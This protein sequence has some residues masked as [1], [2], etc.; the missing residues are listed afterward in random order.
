MTEY[1]NGV[2]AS[3]WSWIS[4]LTVQVAALGAF[5]W[6]VDLPMRRRGWPQVRYALWAV[7]FVK[8]MLPPTLALPTGMAGHLLAQVPSA[9]VVSPA[10][11]ERT[12]VADPD[13]R[14]PVAAYPAHLA[15]RDAMPSSA[16]LSRKAWAM[17]AWLAVVVSLGTWLV[18]RLAALSRLVG[19]GAP[20][21]WA[22]ECLAVAASRMGIKRV[23]RIVAVSGM[24]S[25]AVFGLFRPVVLIPQSWRAEYSRNELSHVLLHEAAHIRRL[26]LVANALQ[27][28]LHLLFWFHPFVWLAGR[29][30]RELRELCCDASVARVL[31]TET[32]EYR[33]TLMAAAGRVL[34]MQPPFSLGLLGLFEN[35]ARFRVRL[36]HLA[37]PLWQRRRLRL[38]TALVVVTAMMLFVVPMAPLKAMSGENV[39]AAAAS[40]SERVG[41]SQAVDASPKAEQAVKC[42]GRVVDSEGNGVAGAEVVIYQPGADASHDNVIIA[43]GVSGADGVFSFDATLASEFMAYATAWKEGYAH[44][45]YYW[46]P[47]G[48]GGMETVVRLGKP[49]VL[50][51]HVVDSSGKPISGAEVRVG[52]GIPYVDTRSGVG[53]R[54][55]GLSEYRKPAIDWLITTTGADGAFSFKDIPEDAKA[56]VT[57]SAP[58][59]ARVSTSRNPVQKQEDLYSYDAGQ[60][61]IVVTLPPES[62][63]VGKVLDRDTGEGVGGVQIW[64][65]PGATDSPV[66]AADGTFRVGALGAREYTLSVN[67]ATTPDRVAEPVKVTTAAGETTGGVTIVLFG[68]G[69]L[70]VTVTDESTG[71]PIPGASISV[72][73]ASA[74]E[75]E[76]SGGGAAGDNGVATARLLPG[77]YILSQV[78][79]PAR[80]HNAATPKE[81]VDIVYGGT[82]TLAVALSPTLSRLE[83][84]V[85]DADGAP[86]DGARFSLAGGTLEPGEPEPR[87]DASGRFSFRVRMW[88][89]DMAERP[90]LFVRLPEKG[91]AA[92]VD[93]SE[94]PRAL[95]ITLKPAPSVLGKVT[96]SDGKPLAGATVY[97]TTR[98]YGGGGTFMDTGITGRDTVSAADG[99][100]L[101][102][103]IPPGLSQEYNLDV[104]AEGFARKQMPVLIDETDPSMV[105]APVVALNRAD[106]TISGRVVDADGK[107]AAGADIHAEYFGPRLDDGSTQWQQDSAHAAADAEGRFV[108]KGVTGGKVQV[109]VN[110]GNP[111]RHAQPTLDAPSTDVT[112]TVLTEDEQQRQRDEEALRRLGVE[113]PPEPLLGKPAPPLGALGVA[114]ADAPAGNRVLVCFWDYGSRPSRAMVEALGGRA[115]ALSD[116]GLVVVCVHAGG[117]A[118]AART[119]FD[120]LKLG[121]PFGAATG[122][123]SEVKRAWGISALPWLVLVGADGKVEAEGFSLDD[124]DGLLAQPP[125]DR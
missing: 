100:Y 34:A 65:R 33:R 48:A 91:L 49:T 119:W 115:K 90:A 85:R 54:Y 53:T 3:W 107:P 4:V 22:G 99:T 21:G 19:A 101:I 26:D 69:L 71:A 35:P 73:A 51:G 13:A 83:G 70:E 106:A 14:G 10:A 11:V 55:I 2:A 18:R 61:D 27:T 87:S 77:K 118:D 122:D 121:L 17:L 75:Y 28:T 30:A 39:A 56:Y 120:A 32:V 78:Y 113:A 88:P 36:E 25:A 29:R 62:V 82:V 110:W 89:S 111:N 7:V 94:K 102:T 15:S 76:S 108:L 63:I 20:A 43:K 72:R 64:V 103:A 79:D 109:G 116:K 6:L 38:A 52:A 86:V 31:R 105:D 9:A 44:G 114:G 12:A 57:A 50:S 125:A 96:D 74:P 95:D 123:L 97:V 42:T 8:L 16:A 47:S 84:V 40:S 58:G 93:V 66:T 23:P 68:G 1:I 67:T 41:G 37:R 81:E 124:L 104:R 112:I 59:Y 80:E 5:A 92:M 98:Q 24:K 117:D 45:W 46:S 60:T